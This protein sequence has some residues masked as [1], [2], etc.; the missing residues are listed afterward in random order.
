MCVSEEELNK[1]K[2]EGIRAI[3]EEVNNFGTD[4]DKECLQYVLNEAAG[5]SDKTF[6]DGLKRDCDHDGG[7][8]PE[9]VAANG[10]GMRL[11]D[12]NG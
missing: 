5:S 8:L 3:E 1:R 12:L 2:N 11:A 4:V 6:Q 7:L 10:E 9:R